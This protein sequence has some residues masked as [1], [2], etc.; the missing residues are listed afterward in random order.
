MSRHLRILREAGV[1]KDEADE[2]DGRAT[3]IALERAPFD[4]VRAFLDELDGFW[5]S[6][7]ASFGSL[8]EKRALERSAPAK[9]RNAS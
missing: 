4:D 1:L 8:A 3:R 5:S 7:L 9:K 2:R 6:Q